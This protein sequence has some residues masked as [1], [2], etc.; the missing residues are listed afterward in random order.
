MNLHRVDLTIAHPLHTVADTRA[1]EAKLAQLLSPHE[2]M[3][4][5]GQAAARLAR[6]VAPHAKSIWIACGPG[7]NGGDGLMAAAHLAEWARHHNKLLLVTWCGDAARC[8]ADSRYA[9]QLAREADVRFVDSPPPD[10][11]LAMDALYGIGLRATDQGET[12]KRVR[13]ETDVPM[14]WLTQLQRAEILIQLDMPSGLHS[15]TGRWA[16]HFERIGELTN[17]AFNSIGSSARGRF[18]LNFLTLK[19]G[20]FTAQGQAACG[21]HWLDDLGL[22]ELLPSESATNAQTWLGV[23]KMMCVN[24]FVSTTD[25]SPMIGGDR[26]KGTYGDVW[27]VGGQSMQENGHGM[28]GA[29]VL[30]ARAALHAGAGRVH[31]VTLGEPG[32]SWDGGQPELMCRTPASCFE[33]PNFPQGAWVCGCGGGNAVTQYLPRVMDSA[34][35]LVL[36]ADALNAIAHQ[37]ELASQLAGRR[38]QGYLTVL[39][40]H[41]LEAARLLGTSTSAVQ[42]DR[43][44]AARALA[45][46]FGSVCVLKGVGTVVATPAGMVAIQSTG[47]A[48]LATAGTGDVL[49]GMVGAAMAPLAEKFGIAS[50]NEQSRVA[51][52]KMA[53]HWVCRAVH[54]HGSAADHWPDRVALTASMLARHITPLWSRSA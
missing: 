15:E 1:L 8:S 28:T 2:L 32:L 23:P 18:N 25:S 51:I 39:T 16:I 48:K 24:A 9:L 5:A 52:E 31:L 10:V 6:A 11:D 37:P 40:P 14:E 30:A 19:P 36:D 26:H 43:V 20:A 7:N 3:R 35:C 38:P 17:E 46:K 53:W 12:S 47:N 13:P 42:D 22:S 54:A 34:R 44:G 45:S 49:A 29:A 50:D 21:E 33:V 41:P 27:V 4:R